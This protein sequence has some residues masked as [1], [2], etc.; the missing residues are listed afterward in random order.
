MHLLG[1]WSFVVWQPAARRLFLARDQFGIT[2]LYY[3]MSDAGIAFATRRKLLLALDPQLTQIDDLYVAQL[4]LAWK[5]YTGAG[6]PHRQIKRLPP[7]H[8]LTATAAGATTVR[9]Y[10]EMAAAVTPLPVRTV[11]EAGEGLRALFDEAVRCRCAGD[12]RIAVSLSGGLDSSAV[13][14]TAAPLL[15]AADRV[16]SAYTSV[17]LASDELTVRRR[18]GNEWSLAATS[19][20]SAANIRHHA[21]RASTVSPL[22]GI[23]AALWIHDGP[24][25]GA[26]NAHWMHELMRMARAAGDQVLLTG[27]MGNLAMSWTGERSADGA[28]LGR[29]LRAVL[30]FGL[31]RAVKRWRL[32]RAVDDGADSALSPD[33]A[34]RLRV[35]DADGADPFHP[36]HPPIADNLMRRA[37]LLGAGRTIG[38]ALLA[39]Q[40][41][42]FGLEVRDPTADIRVLCYCLAVPPELF[43]DPA[44]GLDRMLIRTAMAGRVPDAVRLN[45]RR[46]VQSADIIMRLRA[47][48][49]AMEACL[50]ELARGE[51]V[52]YVNLP[53]LRRVWQDVQVRDDDDTYLAAKSV[54][55][56]GIMVGLFVQQPGGPRPNSA[57]AAFVADGGMP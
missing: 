28:G 52:N 55:L 44:T 29:R 25:H 50:D 27:Q 14:L 38:G 31:R 57:Q 36:L 34:R 32:L 9:C 7:A 45:R 19:A 43:V 17:P 11:A 5:V 51:A 20:G 41:A 3:H 23:R 33:L 6:T 15:L 48:R 39:E 49:D 16:L 53:A 56:R 26:G 37:T 47:D 30:P 8:S 12:A 4:L 10:W 54:L 46:G 21:V 1:D 13:A 40:G 24:V 22:D 35:V 18:F 42:A 2:S